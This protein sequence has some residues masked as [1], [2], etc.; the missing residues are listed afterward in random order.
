[1]S[2]DALKANPLVK[3]AQDIIIEDRY[4]HTALTIT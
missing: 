4:A 2:E 1:M 3:N